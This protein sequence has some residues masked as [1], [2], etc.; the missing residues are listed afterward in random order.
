MTT[1]N[2]NKN[3]DFENIEIYLQKCIKLTPLSISAAL[4]FA[5]WAVFSGNLSETWIFIFEIA[6]IPILLAVECTVFMCIKPY[7]STAVKFFSGIATNND[8]NS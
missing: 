8:K 4:L 7:I 6:L 3:N 5:A 2:K 1:K